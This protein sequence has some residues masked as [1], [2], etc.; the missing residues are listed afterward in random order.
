MTN[1]QQTMAPLTLLRMRGLAT[2]IEDLLA[3]DRAQLDMV[4]WGW[5]YVQRYDRS[6]YLGYPVPDDD[7][8]DQWKNPHCKTV[9]CLAGWSTLAPYM[10]R[11]GIPKV[12]ALVSSWVCDSAIDLI[13]PISK[14]FIYPNRASKRETLT[15]LRDELNAISARF[16]GPAKLEPFGEY[17]DIELAG[18]NQ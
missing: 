17:E 16:G 4:D 9:C 3:D 15:A 5:A 13:K 8:A 10:L 1:T 2:V 14:L 12:P 7:R 11:L 6:I 18:I